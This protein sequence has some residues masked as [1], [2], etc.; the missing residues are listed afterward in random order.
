VGKGTEQR[1]VPRLANEAGWLSFGPFIALPIGQYRYTLS[2]VS[3]TSASVHTGNWE[4]VLENKK[5]LSTG[6]LVGT[7]GQVQ[8]IEG[9]FSIDAQDAGKPY[10]LRTFYLA[11]GDLQIVNSSLQIVP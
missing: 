2:Y 5:I 10:E 3:Q 1:L 7:Q 11:K 9:T 4:A 8:K 6:K